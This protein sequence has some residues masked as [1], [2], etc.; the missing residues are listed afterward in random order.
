MSLGHDVFGTGIPPMFHLRHSKCD[1]SDF[2]RILTR[3][4]GTPKNATQQ[5]KD[6]VEILKTRQSS[7]RKRVWIYNC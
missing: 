5:D 3:Q 7:I 2:R 1:K 4:F 6:A